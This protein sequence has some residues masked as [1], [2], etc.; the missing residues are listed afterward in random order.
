[1]SHIM[2]TNDRIDFRQKCTKILET[3]GTPYP[4]RRKYEDENMR[5]LSG[6]L[7][8]GLRLKIT[9]ME[10]AHPD[11]LASSCVMVD[12]DGHCIRHHGEWKYLENHVN[13]VFEDA[14]WE[15]QSL[16]SG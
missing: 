14:I 3:L 16:N 8:S 2:D 13:N 7:A 4:G 11:G 10:T 15:W 6:V 9:I 12:E 1:M 5:I